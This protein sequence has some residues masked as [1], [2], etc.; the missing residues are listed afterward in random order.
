MLHAQKHHKWTS[1]IV[2]F[3]TV[4]LLTLVIS[5]SVHAQSFLDDLN[6]QTNSF[7]GTQGVDAGTASD[8]RL[9]IARVIRYALGLLGMMFMG[10]VIFA[11]YLFLT[12]AGNDDQVSRAKKMMATSVLGIIITMSAYSLT[13]FVFRW[14][15]EKLNT[16]GNG[17]IQTEPDYNSC[18]TGFADPASCP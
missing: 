9:I 12:A 7:A 11:G 3:A 10:Y 5:H 8:P 18:N 6:R 17:L 2:L 4:V 15:Q 13:V 1:P 16:A 14:Q